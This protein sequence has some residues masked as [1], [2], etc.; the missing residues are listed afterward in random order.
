M[1]RMIGLLCFV[2]VMVAFG[3]GCA[4]PPME[5]PTKTSQKPATELPPA[6]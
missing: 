4:S 3:A 2:A 1:K 5:Y 6:V